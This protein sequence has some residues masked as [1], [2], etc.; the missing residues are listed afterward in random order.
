MQSSNISMAIRETDSTTVAT[1]ACRSFLSHTFPYSF[2]VACLSIQV[3]ALI[4][5]AQTN[6]FTIVHALCGASTPGHHSTTQNGPRS[7]SSFRVD[8]PPTS[9]SPVP[10]R[11]SVCTAP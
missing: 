10:R 11:H 3:K 4:T 5:H 9:A 2:I 6:V 1:Q 8:S 7:P